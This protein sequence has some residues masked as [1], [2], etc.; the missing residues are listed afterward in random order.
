MYHFGFHRIY[1][2]DVEVKIGIKFFVLLNS[3]N[4]LNNPR[5]ILVLLDNDFCSWRVGWYKLIVYTKA[6]TCRAIAQSPQLW[7]NGGIG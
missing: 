6:N 7:H 2:G 4:F 5:I 1:R 3:T